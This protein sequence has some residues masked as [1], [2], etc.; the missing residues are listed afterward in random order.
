MGLIRDLIH[1]GGTG[2]LNWHL[3]AHY[4]RERWQPTVQLIEQFLLQVSPP[5]DHLLL[6][7]GSAGWMMPQAW[8]ARFTRIDAYDIDPL[9]HG[10]FK[11]RKS[12]V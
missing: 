11:D 10:L 7:G 6:I 3:H 4:S 8:L 12:V 2:G 9:A 1:A 5:S